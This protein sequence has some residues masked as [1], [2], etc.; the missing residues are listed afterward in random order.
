MKTL[1]GKNKLPLPFKHGEAHVYHGFHGKSRDGIYLG[2]ELEFELELDTKNKNSFGYISSEFNQKGSDLRRHINSINQNVGRFGIIKDD[3][4]LDYGIEI[5]SAPVTYERH[6]HLWD[7]FFAKKKK[8]YKLKSRSN[9]GM[10]VHVSR[11]DISEEQIVRLR[12]FFSQKDNQQFLEKI[13]GR[14]ENEYCEYRMV[15]LLNFK[16]GLDYSNEEEKKSLKEDYPDYPL[17]DF[18]SE[19]YQAIN[20][21]PN[22]TIEFRIFKAPETREEF[23]IRVQLVRALISWQKTRKNLTLESFKKFISGNNKFKE[24]HEFVLKKNL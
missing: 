14:K 9:C 18:G 20:I 23:L 16:K 3:G 4:S 12:Y 22:D 6:V 24:L 8:D 19:K 21:S 17:E 1:T 13:A 10:H 15:G 5:A 2:V 7:E 11:K